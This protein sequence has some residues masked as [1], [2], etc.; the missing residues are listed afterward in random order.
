MDDW[1]RLLAATQGLSAEPAR[2]LRER[3]FVVIP[4]PVD[5]A[6]LPRLSAAYDAA[7]ASASAEDVRISSST[8]VHD[9]V[10]RGP[11]FDPLYVYGPLLAGCCGVIGR[12][13]KL[14]TMLARTLEPGA[15]AQELHVDVGRGSDLAR[16]H[17]Q[18]VRPAPA[19]HPG[20]LHPA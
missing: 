11:D 3:G 6:S 18:P 8:R 15:P 19:L 7:V 1:F 17:G 12:P 20:R 9:F 14:S 5:G 2:Q 16:S 10:N 4:G 13:F